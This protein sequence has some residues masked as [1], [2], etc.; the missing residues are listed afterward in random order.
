MSLKAVFSTMILLNLRPSEAVRV[1]ASE[2]LYVELD[3]DNFTVFGGRQVEDALLKEVV[4]NVVGGLRRYVRTNHMPYQQGDIDADIIPLESIKKRMIKWL[5]VGA[6]L[7]VSVAVFHAIRT[8]SRNP[9]EMNLEFFK[10]MAKEAIDRGIMVAVEN[11]MERGL[12]GS[13]PS[14]LKA[15]ME[16]VGEGIGVCLDVGHANITK[17]LHRFLDELGEHIVELHLHDNDGLK[18]L[19]KPPLTGTVDWNSIMLWLRNKSNVI[20][21]FEIGCRE[22][23]RSCLAVAKSV[24]EWFRKH[25]HIDT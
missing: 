7:G 19:H 4:E 21:T 1:L 6:E 9:L 16:G 15:L 20:P 18:D 14:D 12:F 13:K 17:N 25:L 24:L 10:V 23:T 2:G 22:D 3:Y 8:S 5:D 11:R